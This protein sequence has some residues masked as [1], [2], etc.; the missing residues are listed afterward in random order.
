M[1]KRYT[2]V[3]FD[4]E[5]WSRE[6]VKSLTEWERLGLELVGEADDGDAGLQL[7][8]ATQPH[9]VITDMNMPGIDGPSLL[10]ATEAE[11][12]DARIVV[13]SGYDDFPYVRQALR[14]R[15]E[16]YLLKPIDPEELN[17]TLELCVRSLGA[18]DDRRPESI[19]TPVAFADP[20][21]LEAYVEHR[22]RAFAYLL[23]LD[24]DAVRR[25]LEDLRR[26]LDGAGESEPAED[27]RTRIAHDYLL[28]LEEFM[29]RNGAAVDPSLLRPRGL[30]A[31]DDPLAVIARVYEQVIERM[32]MR[33][34]GDHLDLEEVREHIDHYYRD[35]LSLHGV[36]QM[37]LVSKEHLS[38]AFRKAFGETVRHAPGEGARDRRRR[39]NRLQHRVLRLAKD[40]RPEVV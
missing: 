14:S 7:L 34:S 3:I 31:G 24:A 26:F 15:A 36:A 22:R 29:V 30:D 8:Q 11:H 10:R 9:I 25:T 19:R 37:F 27:L 33:R 40:R 23:E 17:R 12:P 32:R 5:P 4:D 35:P 18:P 13:M 2:V 38:R 39:I 20:T 21:V 6:V 28:M 1:S 16:D